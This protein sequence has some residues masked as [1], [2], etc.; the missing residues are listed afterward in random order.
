MDLNVLPFPAVLVDLAASLLASNQAARSLWPCLEQGCLPE[1]VRIDEPSWLEQDGRIWKWVPHDQRGRVLL[2]VQDDTENHLLRK[3]QEE[4]AVLQAAFISGTPTRKNFEQLLDLFLEQ[5]QSEFGF[6]GEVLQS[7]EGKPF[8]RTLAITNIAWNAETQALYATYESSGLEFPNLNNLFGLAIRTGE[9]VLTNDPANHPAAGGTPPGH[10]PLNSFLALPLKIGEE[11]V[12]LVGVANRPGGYNAELLSALRLPASLTASLIMAYRAARQRDAAVS[13]LQAHREQSNALYVTLSKDG[14]IIDASSNFTRSFGTGSEDVIGKSLLELTHPNERELVQ[15]ALTRLNQGAPMVEFE[16]RFITK[17]GATLWLAWMC[18]M[19]SPHLGEIYATALDI[20][21]VKVLTREHRLLTEVARRTSNAVIITDEHGRIEWVNE[22]FTRISGYTLPEVRGRKPGQIL[23]GPETD[24][25]VVARIRQQLA[26]GKGFHELLLNYRRDGTPYWV[27]IEVQP[28]HDEK[29]KLTHFMAIEQD[30]T[31][32]VERERKLR[33]NEQ[34]LQE[35]AAI[36]HVGGWELVLGQPGPRWSDETCRIHEVPVGYQPTLEEALNFY[37]PESRQ[38]IEN[39]LTRAIQT[40]EE[41]DVECWL[42]TSTG[43]S[44][45]VRVRGRP[46]YHNG[47]CYRLTGII[48]DVTEQYQQSECYAALVDAIP[49]ALIL[50]DS[51]F[52]IRHTHNTNI[53]PAGCRLIQDNSPRLSFD[54]LDPEQ[55]AYFLESLRAVGETHKPITVHYRT[56]SAQGERH[57]EIRGIKT[58]FSDYLFLI[59]DVTE[60]RLAERELIRARKAAEEASNAK[61]EFLAVMSHEIRT[62]LNVILGVARILLDTDLDKQQK[63]NCNILLRAGESLLDIVNDILDFARI[64]SRSIEL[65]KVAFDLHQAVEDVLEMMSMQANDKGL[66]LALWIDLQTPRVVIGDH[67]RFRQMVV[68]YV[69]NAIKFTQSGY[70]YVRLTA[71]AVDRIRVEV[72]DTGIGLPPEK[73]AHIFEPFIQADSSTTRK[74]GGTGLGLAIVKDLASLM[75]GKV[76]AQSEPGK[77]SCFWFEIALVGYP[78]PLLS[79]LKVPTIQLMGS[80]PRLMVLRRMMT[81]IAATYSIDKERTVTIDADSLL[82]PIVGNRLLGI[83]IESVSIKQANTDVSEAVNLQGARVLLVEDNVMNQKVAVR[84]LNKVGCS[85]DV[86]ANGKEALSVAMR[87][88]YDAILMDCQMPIMDGWEA[89]RRLRQFGGKLSRIPII[90]LTA[91][92]TEAELRRC[93]EAGMNDYL[94]KPVDFRRLG[95]TLCRFIRRA[96]ERSNGG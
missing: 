21:F 28:I 3:M 60:Q 86:A 89:T 75:H 72:E 46:E 25:E 55:R 64:E 56:D 62:P 95:Q 93:V 90:G 59:R 84:L 87:L 18:S 4:L 96:D 40:G 10:P 77:G 80:G 58:V 48:Q 22:G 85:V 6:L 42:R 53:L 33:E 52:T 61:S 83:N 74:F 49:D 78:A 69:N 17:T 16:A 57:L 37:P 44:R 94:T 36:A 82:S 7:K 8:L 15:S 30:V 47:K 26:R 43:K 35:S 66:A 45:R 70:I 9:V 68:N 5:T 91:A 32:D 73:L 14:R 54:C 88:D 81:D 31:I 41:W 71:P 12:G 20:T 1:G 38:L 27:D 29:G 51:D 39:V 2:V 11:M 79:E 23:Q 65:E 50:T 19:P 92:V 67:A 76:G 13:E 24:A 34:L 63:E